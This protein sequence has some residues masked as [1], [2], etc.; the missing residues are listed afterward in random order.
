MATREDILGWICECSDPGCPHCQGK[1]DEGATNILYR[2]DM[3]D[4]TGTVMCEKCADDALEGGL[5]YTKD[6]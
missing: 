4:E 5:F 3:D 1:C 2:C 6:D